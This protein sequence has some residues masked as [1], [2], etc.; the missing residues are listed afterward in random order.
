M[1]RRFLRCVTEAAGVMCL[2]VPGA[3]FYSIGLGLVVSTLVSYL[4]NLRASGTLCPLRFCS[5]VKISRDL[6]S[7]QVRDHHGFMTGFRSRG[8]ISCSDAPLGRILGYFYFGFQ[9]PQLK[10]AILGNCWRRASEIRYPDLRAMRQI[11]AHEPRV[12]ERELG[13]TLH[14]APCAWLWVG[15]HRG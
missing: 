3:K 9:L 1:S 2:G 6:G 8:A 11:R 13:T 10:K 15:S 7:G 12:L 5:H 4:L 14:A